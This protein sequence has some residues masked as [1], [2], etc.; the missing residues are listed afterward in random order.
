[1]FLRQYIGADATFDRAALQSDCRSLPL[2][3]SFAYF[4]LP[5]FHCSGTSST[6]AV[7]VHLIGF[8]GMAHLQTVH[9]D[10]LLP[11]FHLVRI[12]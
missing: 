5:L 6:V 7:G 2:S 11:Q 3:A 8:S 12:A 1:M 10:L 4:F 9:A